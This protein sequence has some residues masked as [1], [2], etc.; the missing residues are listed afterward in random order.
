MNHLLSRWR[1]PSIAPHRNATEVVTMKARDIMRWSP[2]VVTPEEAV[3]HAAEHM[4]YEH[5]ACIS[6]VKDKKTM[7]LAGVITARD[8]ATRCLARRHGPDCTVG[9]HM[10]PMPL[11]TVHLDDDISDLLTTMH[12]A[13]VR[14]LPVVSDDGMLLGIVT[15]SAVTEALVLT[16]WLAPSLSK[17]PNGMQRGGFVLN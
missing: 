13:G 3:S 14:R 15:E 10:T 8:L 5:D 7:E 9:D 17:M 12:T 11:L 1:R 6:V 4:R 2:T 16:G